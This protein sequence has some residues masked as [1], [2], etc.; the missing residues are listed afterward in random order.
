MAPFKV[1]ACSLDSHR[2]GNNRFLCNVK[3]VFQLVGKVL[4]KPGFV[5]SMDWTVALF[6]R[7]FEFALERVLKNEVC[8]KLHAICSSL[9]DLQFVLLFFVGDL[10]V[11]EV[12][13]TAEHSCFV[14]IDVVLQVFN[15]F[16]LLLV[17]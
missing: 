7:N 5:L 11:V 13:G 14:F 9:S 8:F 15:Q 16:L 12:V 2:L 17:L 4:L 10:E 3:V 1:V 6:K